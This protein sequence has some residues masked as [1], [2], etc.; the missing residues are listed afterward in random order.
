MS[1]SFTGTVGGREGEG[2]EQR[3]LTKIGKHKNE[4]RWRCN[5]KVKNEDEEEGGQL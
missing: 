2:G 4:G 5:E 3:A 1:L